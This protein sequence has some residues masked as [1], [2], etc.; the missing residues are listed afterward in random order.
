MAKTA[1]D[2]I[3]VARQT[4]SVENSNVVTDDELLARLNLAI[5]DLFDLLIS[6]DA[7]YYERARDY[8]LASSPAGATVTLPADF[9]KLRGVVRYPDTT[10]EYPIYLR[11]FSE[12]RRGD[13]VGYTL[14]GNTLAITPW[15]N[16]GDGPWRV[17]YTPKPP[18][19][20]KY[21]V[22]VVAGSLP[23][24]FTRVGA[25]ETR[26]LLCSDGGVSAPLTIDG[27]TLARGDL[28]LLTLSD[29][30]IY[31]VLDPGQNLARPWSIVRW[32]P[33]S[34]ASQMDYGDLVTVTAGTTFAGT[35]WYQYLGRPGFEIDLDGTVYGGT[36]VSPVTGLTL[37]TTPA[38]TQNATAALP[39]TML[40][41]TL[42]N[43]DDYLVA[44]LA[45]YVFAKRQ[46][47]PGLTP[48]L[49]AAAEARVRAL[50]AGRA[51]EPE[52]APVLWGGR[53][54][55]SVYDDIDGC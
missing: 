44:K 35:T 18:Q 45:L 1:A 26:A 37:S 29:G 55:R 15:V 3:A 12:R 13:V 46:M 17:I 54:R 7:S 33:Y 10:R 43:F 28:V 51:S 32:E 19:L 11:P 2:I 14:D 20:R 36:K 23:A 4:A 40:D 34:D 6:V 31:Y 8:T 5:K 41:P 22:R 53:R 52:Q 42:D 47:D 24:A 39:L 48:G 50:S 16:A 30:G 38:F 21:Q 25:A 49:F 9:Y 27:V